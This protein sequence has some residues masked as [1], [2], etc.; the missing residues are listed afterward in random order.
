MAPTIRPF[1]P[2]DVP[3]LYR[4]CLI[5]GEAGRDATGLY[6]DPDLLG[7]LYAGPYPVADPTLTF[8]VAD[9]E[10]V[11]G[12]VVATADSLG[13]ARWLD[14]QWWPVLRAQHPRRPDPGDGSQDHVLVDRLHDWPT[15]PLP[16]YADF[17]AHLH[18]DLAPR[19]QG[20]GWGRRLIGTLA[21]ALRARGVPGVHLGVSE[22]NAGAI[23]FYTRLGFETFATHEWG[24]TLTLGLGTSG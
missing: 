6:R 13:F 21:D 24:R 20:Q 22:R 16:Q 18:I 10:G 5:T 8:V 1:H 23:A 17:P 19:L 11:G 7:H 3:G 15:D 14:E 12:Y 2:A 4:L 9:D